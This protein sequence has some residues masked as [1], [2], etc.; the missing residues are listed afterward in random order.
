M[1]IVAEQ[2]GVT[3]E[4]NP[5]E[6]SEQLLRVAATPELSHLARAI[7]LIVKALEP[8]QIGRPRSK[9]PQ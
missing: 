9:T 2:R 6:I 1:R 3:E 7:G 5:T 8:R 4:L